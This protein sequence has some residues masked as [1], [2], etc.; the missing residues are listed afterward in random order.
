MIDDDN[1]DL[2]Y[3]Q[4]GDFEPGNRS[5]YL[6]PRNPFEQRLSANLRPG[7]V[8][9]LDLETAAR[10][11]SGAALSAGSRKAVAFDLDLQSGRFEVI[12]VGSSMP[13]ICADVAGNLV[14]ALCWYQRNGF[15][16]IYVAVQSPDL[17][18]LPVSPASAGTLKQR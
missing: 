12:A 6:R 8:L 4:C 11:M 17:F 13:P 3:L 10:V 5:P 15:Q 18:W 9:R 7:L 16:S 2:Q 1:V 14:P